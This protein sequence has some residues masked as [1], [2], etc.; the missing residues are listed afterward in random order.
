MKLTIE[1]ALRQAAAAQKEGRLGDAQSLYRTILKIRPLH[2]VANYN[3][4]VLEVSLNK[5]SEALPFLKTALETNSKTEQ[6][7]VSYIDALIREQQFD[8]AEQ[9]LEEAKK[10]GLAEEKLNILKAQLA[11]TNRA[12]NVGGL[13]P[14]K[15]QLSNLFGHYQAGRLDEAEKVATFI[16]QKYPTHPF[17]WNVLAAV[18]NQTGRFTESLIAAQQAVKLA[19]QDATAHNNLG[20]TLK[21]LRRFEEAKVSYRQAIT[22]NPELAEAYN[23]LGITL[24]ELGRSEDSEA[25]YRQAIELK[26]DFADA[27]HNLGVTLKALGRLDESMD[28]LKQAIDLNPDFVNAKKSLDGVVNAA[29][30]GWHIPMMNEH[31]R[32]EAYQKAI[33][34]VIQGDEV[35]LDIGTGAGL[36]SMIAADRGAKEIITCEMS[37]TISKIAGRIIKKNGFEN[38]IRIINK[39]SKDLILGQDI[40]NKADILVSEILSSEFVGEGVQTT[41]LDAKRRLLKKNGKVI[42]ERGSIMIALI[43]NTEKLAKELFVDN[44]LGFDISNFNVITAKKWTTTFREG[45]VFL[46]DPTEAFVFDFRNFEKIYQD[47]KT[48]KMEVNRAGA[49]AGLVQWI[50]IQ[51]YDDIEYQNNPTEMYRSNSVSGWNTPIFKFIEPIDVKSGDILDINASLQEDSVW[52]WKN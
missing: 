15:E 19:P 21:E 51:L 17:S 30:P 41:I 46:S 5:T 35:V 33:G 16:T 32:N 52:F 2:S 18:L 29:V 20:N 43:E 34:S 37:A 40:S 39:N 14:S 36:L 47:K 23:N 48:I 7:W 26:P 3:L 28:H 10:H 13:I 22:L 25:S 44:V 27:H 4:G 50:K 12:K 42:P 1:Q 45:P 31:R 38:K 6:Y 11:L 9:V 24:K 8:N 49:C